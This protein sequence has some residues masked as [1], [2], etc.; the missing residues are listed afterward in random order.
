MK[1]VV[2]VSRI[3]GRYE[4]AGQRELRDQRDEKAA[5]HVDDERAVGKSRAQAAPGEDAHEVARQG[6]QRARETDQQ[7]ACHP[8]AVVEA[9]GIQALGG[10]R[11]GGGYERGSSARAGGA[12]VLLGR[13][14]G[15]VRCA[16]HRVEA[17]HVERAPQ[18][19]A[20]GREL[21]AQRGLRDEDLL[22]PLARDE[23]PEDQ[24][25]RRERVPRDVLDDGRHEGDE[26]LDEARERGLL[27]QVVV[28]ERGVGEARGR[29]LAAAARTFSA[30]PTRPA[31]VL[32]GQLEGA[33]RRIVACP[34]A[35]R[36]GGLAVGIHHEIEPVRPAGIGAEL[37][38]HRV[39]VVHGLGE[40]EAIEP[41]RP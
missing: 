9:G 30:T 19:G 32:R 5:E 29:Q 26:L 4:R 27:A 28:V 10:L 33:G 13:R 16:R 40:Q 31:A 6:A 2:S 23:A 14:R 7:D 20:K 11:G 17:Q 15:T 39:P 41:L 37:E 21:V 38:R 8:V 3:V 24:L 22:A 34:R 35:S 12:V 36:R 18:V 25:R 1:P